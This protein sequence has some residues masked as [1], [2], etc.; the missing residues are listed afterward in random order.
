MTER[1]LINWAARYALTQPVRR[2]RRW[3]LVALTR[4]IEARYLLTG[5]LPS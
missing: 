2:V 3:P 4:L 1:Q 5:R